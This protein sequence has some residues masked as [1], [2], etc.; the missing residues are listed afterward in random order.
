PRLRQPRRVEQPG[1]VP[2]F[3]ALD[4]IGQDLADDGA[5]LVAVAGEA[6]GDDYLRVSGVRGDHEV[7]VRGEGVH[8]GRGAEEGAG[9]IGHAAGQGAPDRRGLF[10]VNGPVDRFGRA[11]LHVGGLVEGNLDA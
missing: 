8:A 2:G 3:A 1:W 6:A 10:R 9:E 4:E 11:A 7:L 5:E